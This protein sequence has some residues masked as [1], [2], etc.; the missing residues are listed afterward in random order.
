MGKLVF[1]RFLPQTG[2]E[3]AVEKILR[4][5]LTP[6]RAEEGNQIYDLFKTESPEGRVI[7]HLLER[8]VDDAAVAFHRE[9]AHYK[10]Y[11]EAVVPLL[12]DPISVSFLTPLDVK[13]L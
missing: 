1:V 11:R 13:A 6:T 2:Q 10:A 5:M 3:D 12:E 9:T 8:Y 7:Y 4:G